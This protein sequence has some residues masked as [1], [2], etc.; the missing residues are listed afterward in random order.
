MSKCQCLC[1][2][3][4][5]PSWLAPSGCLQEGTA[6]WI[7][8]SVFSIWSPQ[9]IWGMF[10]GRYHDSSL[11]NSGEVS[12][13]KGMFMLDL[14]G[15]IWF[16]NSS[17]GERRKVKKTRLQNARPEC[18]Q[19]GRKERHFQGKAQVNLNDCTGEMEGNPEEKRCGNHRFGH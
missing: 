11:K 5:M 7:F 15:L 19:R 3:P 9:S 10:R 12:A 16:L 6:L 18:R 8:S 14:R 2:E 1:Q 17:K 4:N 13:E